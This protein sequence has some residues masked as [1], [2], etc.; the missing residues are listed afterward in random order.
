MYFQN[1]MKFY[2]CVPELLIDLVPERDEGA[3]RSIS[4]SRGVAY[5]FVTADKLWEIGRKRRAVQ[6]GDA[7]SGRSS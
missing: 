4:Y 2:I 1:F 6:R 3:L 7:I 5:R